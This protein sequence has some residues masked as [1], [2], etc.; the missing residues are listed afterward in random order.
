MQ[1]SVSTQPEIIQPEIMK[2]ETINQPAPRLLL[3]GTSAPLRSIDPPCFTPKGDNCANT[4]NTTFPT[5][6]CR[7][8]M[9]HVC[10]SRPDSGLGFQAKVSN[11][12]KVFPLRSQAV[13]ML[14]DCR[15][16]RKTSQTTG[17]TTNLPLP[18]KS[19]GDVTIIVS[20]KALILIFAGQVEFSEEGCSPPCGGTCQSKRNLCY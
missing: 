7:A 20:A 17:W 18:R 12:F 3:S 1:Q 4:A 5:S 8:N 11:T 14:L 9:V 10:Q 2:P 13:L 16:P 19:A 15:P 6:R